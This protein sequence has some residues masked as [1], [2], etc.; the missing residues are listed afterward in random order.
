MT[1]HERI[2]AAYTGALAGRDPATVDV[3]TLLPAIFAA[4]PDVEVDEIIDVL[5]R[6][7]ERDFAEADQ[8]TRYRNAKFG[9][10]N[11]Q[12]TPGDG[13]IPFRRR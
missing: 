13:T 11:K 3:V 8:L 6:E 2:M 4:M 9:N 7:A 10:A 5:E 12:A 1:R